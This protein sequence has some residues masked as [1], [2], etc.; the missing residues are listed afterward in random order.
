MTLRALRNDRA[1]CGDNETGE[2]GETGG[3]VFV[4]HSLLFYLIAPRSI[5][6]NKAVS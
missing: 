4:Y 5:F 3:G 1:V 2:T 6:G